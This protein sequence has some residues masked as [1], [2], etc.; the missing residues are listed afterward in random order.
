MIL[1][2]VSPRRSDGAFEVFVYEFFVFCG[3]VNFLQLFNARI[4]YVSFASNKDVEE[5]VVSVFQKD[6]IFGRI[7]TCRQSVVAVD[8]SN[9]QVRQAVGDDCSVQFAD[10]QVFRI[11]SYVFHGSN[12]IGFI[13]AFKRV[14]STI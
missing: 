10:N 13:F 8:N 7:E 14:I 3:L 1:R 4:V 2:S 9:G 11:S 6:G 12:N 5:R